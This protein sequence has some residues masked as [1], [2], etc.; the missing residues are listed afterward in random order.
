[1]NEIP[2][3]LSN[4][5][6]TK[7]EE[8]IHLKKILVDKLSYKL[9][10]IIIMSTLLLILIIRIIL[11]FTSPEYFV[12]IKA[13]MMCP[14]D[15]K[16]FKGA[17]K[18]I[19]PHLQN[20]WSSNIDNF[21]SKEQFLVVAGTAIRN[22]EKSD[23]FQNIEVKYT[24]RF[25][26]LRKDGEHIIHEGKEHLKIFFDHSEI[27]SYTEDFLFYNGVKDGYYRIEIILDI[28][29]ENK[30]FLD[31]FSFT[32]YK[33][34]NKV[35]DAVLGV[36]YTFFALSLIMF[37]I[38]AYNY[39]KIA[40]DYRT[41]EHHVIFILS[42]SLIF[43]NDPFIAIILKNPLSKFWSILSTFFVTQF[44]CLLFYFF[45]ILAKRYD[46]EEKTVYTKQRSLREIIAV[47]VVFV[48]LLVAACI[49][50]V[51]KDSHPG[52]FKENESI[53]F[54]VLI[55]ITALLVLA[56]WIITLFVICKAISNFKKLLIR[57]KFLM[58][59]SLIALIFLVF[60][61]ITGYYHHFSLMPG[62]TI[63][64]FI[65]LNLY[66]F[67]LQI[68]WR[69]TGGE[70]VVENDTDPKNKKVKIQVT[71]EEDDDIKDY[72]NNN[73]QQGHLRLGK[74]NY[75]VENNTLGRNDTMG[76]NETI[77]YGKEE[78]KK[79]INMKNNVE[80]VH[81]GV[82]KE[83]KDKKKDKENDEKKREKLSSKYETSSDDKIDED[84]VKEFNLERR[85]TYE[86]HD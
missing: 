4:D 79:N 30:K 8:K 70:L 75:V 84:S 50:N 81:L 40:K 66:V 45:L 33:G 57:Q 78:K 51:D 32:I 56:Y 41:F 2:I 12:P 7:K 62:R 73:N 82:A 1:M 68:L 59:I 22:F 14:T 23:I 28:E 35:I 72:P 49:Y 27:K 83:K 34:N 5:I 86:Y 58:V 48:F 85:Q 64:Y 19:I 36:R 20:K 21:S 10:L 13:E 53:F 37:G 63:V 43:F 17:C 39:I 54:L 15:F 26:H 55:V 74:D 80:L 60:N 46:K 52:Y 29:E 77:D 44:V 71:F 9:R 18:D 25:I 47:S 65:S 3:K 31:A 24:T 16:G 61:I 76:G 6:E 42:I 11:F 38:Y 67:I 69:F